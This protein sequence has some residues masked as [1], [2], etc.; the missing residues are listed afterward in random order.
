MLVTRNEIW[1][2]I[3]KSSIVKLALT[4]GTLVT[5]LLAGAATFR[6]G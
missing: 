4:L 6:V 1:R 5:A 3:V 2:F